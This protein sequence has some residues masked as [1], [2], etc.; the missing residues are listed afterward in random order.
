MGLSQ[1]SKKEGA[2]LV[3]LLVLFVCRATLASAIVQPWQGP[4]EPTHFVLA[5]LLAKPDG[6]TEAA[7][8]AAQREVLASMARHRW[9]EPY[10]G[11]SP[12][13]P[14]T[15]FAPDVPRLGGGTYS[16]P[17][18]YGL[19][20][21]VLRVTQPEGLESAYRRLRV[22]SIVLSVATLALAWAGTRL[23]FGP[24]VALGASTVAALHPQFVLTAIAVNPDALANL[25]GAFMWWQVAR[26]VR[27]RRPGMSLVCVLIAAA[28][29]L[30]TKRSA[31]PL[32]AVAIVI[33]ATSLFAPHAVRLTRQF[34]LLM[35][36]ALGVCGVV[37]L[38]AWSEFE[39]PIR[40]LAMFWRQGLDIRR[41]FDAALF[42]QALVYARLSIDYVWLV[43]GW[44]RFP[45]PEPWLWVPRTLTVAGFAGAAVLLIRSPMLRRPLSIAWLFVVVQTV[46]VIGWGFLT[47]SSP[48]GRYLFPVI[49]P[50]TALLWLG[51]TQLAPARFR[52]Y[53]APILIAIVAGLDVT[54]FTAVLI[55]AYLP[56]G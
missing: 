53:A 32:A 27:R 50:A 51:L 54:G 12:E 19:S 33:V 16:E 52:P 22:L 1:A 9:W 2:V 20:A 55:P 28:A 18:Y 29:A 36:S 24:A 35:L 14:P 23:L 6:H 30:L 26:V 4:D 21:A 34:G 48:Q 46:I 43:A 15:R 3:C 7:D 13:P 40:A 39:E 47:L 5:Q 44:L 10:G 38:G 41:P 31:V 11:R 45:A 42:P 25:V 49:A 56:W 17:L 37:V 8:L